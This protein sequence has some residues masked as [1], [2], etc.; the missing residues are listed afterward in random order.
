MSLEG[1]AK[2]NDW[3]SFA[4]QNGLLLEE[5]LGV[6]KY[7]TAGS[8]PWD[9]TQSLISGGPMQ[10]ASRILSSLRRLPKTKRHTSLNKRLQQYKGSLIVSTILILCGLVLFLK[11]ITSLPGRQG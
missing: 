8:N 5:D 11:N 10:T 9:L 4:E 3:F 7:Q 2:Y 1:I 6:P